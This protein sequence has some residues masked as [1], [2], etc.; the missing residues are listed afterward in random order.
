MIR[1]PPTANDP[2]ASGCF[3]G[4]DFARGRLF[5]TV[6]LD[7]ARDVCGRVFNPHQLNLVGPGQ[8]LKA[9]MDHLPLGAM[10]LNR[11]TWGAHVSV[12]PERLNTYGL[13]SLPVRGLARFHVGNQEVEVSPN[14]ACIIGATP[15]FRFEA[16]TQFDQIV[17]RFEWQALAQAWQALSG[18]ASPRDIELQAALP[19]N[20]TAWRALEPV[21]QI[22]AAC[23][24][25]AYAPQV[26]PHVQ[27]RLQELLLTTLLLHAAPTLAASP[28]AAPTP[29]AALVR[30]AQS[31]LLARLAEPV[32]VG[33][34]ARAHGVAIRTLQA[35]FQS[36]CHMGPMQWLREQRLTAVHRCLR[37]AAGPSTR[38]TDTALAHGFSHMG[39]FSLA[40]RRRFGE[41]PSH[42]LARR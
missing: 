4:V 33:M 18:S 14:Q 27:L 31:W 32:A 34:V 2:P 23:A 1:T 26:L 42:T 21:L 29:S 19:L 7:E 5:D 20:G 3:A 36:Q 24:R 9:R 41:T 30:S 39:E 11:L 6:D 35:A 17:L 10:S 15:R 25:G 28:Q 13:V 40:Y 38:I 22:V 8:S 16:E 12:D 37:E